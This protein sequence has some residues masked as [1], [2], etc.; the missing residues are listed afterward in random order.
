MRITPSKYCENYGTPLQQLHK[1]L[2]APRFKSVPKYNLY[3]FFPA[4]MVPVNLL[5]SVILNKSWN[6][7]TETG[8]L[9]CQHTHFT[10]FVHR[11]LGDSR[12]WRD[13]C[14]FFPFYPLLQNSSTFFNFK[15]P[16]LIDTL[17]KLFNA[18]FKLILNN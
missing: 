13:S 1:K 5:V 10:Y 9:F 8:F 3:N 18:N 4:T 12:Q 14:H 17:L 15:K 2:H 16:L 11:E 6:S 7:S